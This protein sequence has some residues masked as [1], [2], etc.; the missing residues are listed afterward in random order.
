MRLHPALALLV[1]PLAGLAQSDPNTDFAYGANIGWVNVQPQRA[2]DIYVDA[3]EHFFAGYIYGANVGWISLGDGTPTNG[4]SY[5][6]TTAGDF[7]V[8]NDGAGN[9]SGYAYGAN[10]GWINFGWAGLNDPNRPRFDL[11]DGEFHGFAY[12]ANCGWVNLGT[13]RLFVGAMN[14]VDS[15]HDGIDDAW[16]MQ[17]FGNLATAGLG[18][19]RDGDGQSDSSEYIADTDP[20]RADDYLKIVSHTYAGGQTQV[21]IQ[22]TTQPSRRYQLQH[23]TDLKTWSDSGL[24]TFNPDAGATTTKAFSFA[25]NAR[26]FFRAVAVLPLP[27]P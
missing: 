12:S 23:S 18:T 26:H 17:W 1:L 3:G 22:F 14:R 5:S 13:G 7:G 19:D 21:S 15:D 6:N 8:N 25:G 2:N 24:G 4:Y 16:E 27:T 9:L 20:L 11:D 10:I